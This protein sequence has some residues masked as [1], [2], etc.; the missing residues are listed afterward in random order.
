MK[1]QLLVFA[2]WMVDFNDDCFD[3]S[4][5]GNLERAVR[6]S[7]D[8]TINEIG[9]MLEEI[10]EMDDSQIDIELNGEP[11][12]EKKLERILDIAKNNR[13]QTLAIRDIIELIEDED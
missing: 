13:S 9:S 11:K 1:K 6:Q 3:P 8:T 10:M 5:E 7:K 2:K 4:T 12:A